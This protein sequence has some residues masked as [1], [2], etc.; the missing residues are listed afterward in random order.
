MHVRQG[1]KTRGA[2]FLERLYLTGLRALQS[3][4]VT[5]PFGEVLLVPGC[6]TGGSIPCEPGS[7]GGMRAAKEGAFLSVALVLGSG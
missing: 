6:L 5:G 2:A 1:K 3:S 7:Q 4:P